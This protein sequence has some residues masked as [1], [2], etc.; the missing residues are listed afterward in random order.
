MRSS[1]A[2]DSEQFLRRVVS[3]SPIAQFVIDADRRV[4]CWNKALE[5][6]SGIQAEEMLGTKR[7]SRAF[8]E[9]ERPCLADLL[10]DET[11]EKI[12]EWYRGGSR[13]VNGAHEATDFFPRMGGNGK[14]LRFTAVA[15][16]DEKGHVVGAVETIEDITE[17]RLLEK[18]VADLSDLKQQLLGTRSLDEKLKLITDAT[19]SIF[20][21]DFARI[22]T[23]RE[24]DLCKVGCRHAGVTEGPDVCRDRTRCLHLMASSGRYTHID[25]G[26]RRVPLGCCK[27]GRVASGEDPHFI[28][29]DVAH[30]PGAHDRE[31]AKSLGLIAF[32][33][34]RLASA[35]GAPMGVLAFF[36]NR[37]IERAEERLLEDLAH[38]ASQV[39]LTGVAQEELARLAA[40]AKHSAELINLAALDGTMIFLNEA[41]SRMLGIASE[42]AGRHHVLEFV[43]EHLRDAVQRDILPLLREGGTW[44]G[45]LQYRHAQTGNLTDVHAIC[46]AVKDPDAGT[47]LY[48]AN[49][50]QDITENKRAEKAL[51]ESEQKYR[52]LVET[53]ETG[54]LILDAQ[55]KVVDANAEYVRLTG[56]KSLAE[57]L[58]RTVVEWTAPHDRERNAAE[59]AKCAAT[60][61][62]RNLVVDY[63][64]PNGVITPI[65]INATVVRTAE[66]TRILSLCR[67]ITERRQLEERLRHSEKMEAIG[68]L[69][70]GVAHDFNNQLT[71]VMGYEIGRASCRERVYRLV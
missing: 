70:G 64:G 24:A 30:D 34:Y 7:H 41:G 17:R 11:T 31:W 36:R 63:A 25:G 28:T 20:G 35:D 10:L 14:W 66:G 23:T 49:V 44:E 3:S 33:G 52:A 16:R 57:I 9:G 71:G 54:F 67:D 46:F 4:V 6:L 56:H 68:Q 48:L 15:L 19:V 58:G 39:I 69:A 51:R 32:A 42:E 21:A 29:N 38:I 22:W 8:Y 12:K 27:I 60:G 13:T 40:I 45:D 47:P 1:P 18:R 37:E 53:T 26:H 5:A 59:V 61:R 50:S 43:P 55:G 2:R 65:E 62:V